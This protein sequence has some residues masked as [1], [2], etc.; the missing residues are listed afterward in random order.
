MS[1]GE[2]CAELRN[3]VLE[4]IVDNFDY[5]R[6][7][8]SHL[9]WALMNFDLIHRAARLAYDVCQDNAN[10]LY[11]K[12]A[13]ELSEEDE[14]LFSDA[15]DITQTGEDGNYEDDFDPEQPVLQA[16]FDHYATLRRIWPDAVYPS[17]EELIERASFASC[18]TPMAELAGYTRAEEHVRPDICDK[19][20]ALVNDPLISEGVERY[21]AL[22]KKNAY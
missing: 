7:N 3:G 11:R 18:G 8:K 20:L 6:D 10:D 16:I 2:R 22:G 13:E 9:A 14:D 15:W 21:K 5:F 19:I 17:D 4:V 1:I 12:I